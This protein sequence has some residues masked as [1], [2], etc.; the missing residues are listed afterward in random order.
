MV[1]TDDCGCTQTGSFTV[2]EASS[3]L[4]LYPGAIIALLDGNYWVQVIPDGGTSP[5]KFRR[6]DLAGGYTAWT[7]SNGFA[8]LAPGNYTFEVQDKNGCTAEVTIEL[9]PFSPRPAIGPAGESLDNSIAEIEMEPLETSAADLREQAGAGNFVEKQGMDIQVFPNPAD[10]E[11]NIGWTGL[12][13][14]SASVEIYNQ[15]GQVFR[16]LE[17]P[18][19]ALRVMVDVH[20]LPAGV[21]F[22]R[23]AAAGGQTQVLRFIKS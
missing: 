12:E 18:A 13:D 15:V 16:T 11:L 5:Y 14:K 9:L 22:I 21:Y 2:T 17:V 8:D 10:G 4:T 23:F 6:N 3:P 19:G 20:E 1:V 7:N